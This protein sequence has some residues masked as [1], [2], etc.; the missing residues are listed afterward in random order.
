M[1]VENS[2]EEYCILTRVLLSIQECLGCNVPVDGLH[3]QDNKRQGVVSLAQAPT[4][5]RRNYTET[6]VQHAPLG[7]IHYHTE[8][9]SATSDK[10]CFK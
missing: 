9:Y 1:G 2:T 4:G 3:T 8:P 7:T 6:S 5:S 10:Q